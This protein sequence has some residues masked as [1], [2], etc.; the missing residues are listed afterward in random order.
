MS[1]ICHQFPAQ[2]KEENPVI[3]PEEAFPECNAVCV[4]TVST[5]YERAIGLKD[6]NGKQKSPGAS[7]PPPGSNTPPTT[8]PRSDQ[9]DS[10]EPVVTAK[11]VLLPTKPGRSGST[12]PP[13]AP[14]KP[15]AE[16]KARLAT[17]PKT[18]V[19]GSKGKP[20]AKPTKSSTIGGG[21]NETIPKEAWNVGRRASD[22]DDLWYDLEGPAGGLWISKLGREDVAVPEW[23]P[24]ML[25][26]GA[27]TMGSYSSYME[28]MQ[29]TQSSTNTVSNVMTTHVTQ[30]QI[31]AGKASSGVKCVEWCPFFDP[32]GEELEFPARPPPP[33]ASYDDYNYYLEQQQQQYNPYYDMQYYDLNHSRQNMLANKGMEG[34]HSTAA[35]F[36][37][38]SYFHPQF[39]NPRF[40][41][42]P[43]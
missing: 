28:V 6:S 39:E 35:T 34:T 30:N 2:T 27:W 13:E 32:Y 16:P 25:D 24:W 19:E 21:A 11:R 9:S 1:S 15:Q 43:P 41:Q 4:G 3:Q 42:M 22:Y 14:P 10:K 20:T 18:K 29:A 26:D 23:R 33:N 7:R 37:P 31:P 36:P 38:A 8:P 40:N 12:T 5:V 17:P